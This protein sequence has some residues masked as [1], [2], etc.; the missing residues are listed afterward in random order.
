MFNF[1]CRQNGFPLAKDHDIEEVIEILDENGDNEIQLEELME[2]LNKFIELV[3]MPSK[4][5]IEQLL[6]E[7][8]RKVDK[9]KKGSITKPVFRKLFDILCFQL[10]IKNFSD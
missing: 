7:G 9:K 2:N 4:V 8:L 10:C 1:I 3:S 6:K 5:R